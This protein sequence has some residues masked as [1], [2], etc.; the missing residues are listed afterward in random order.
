M[1][2]ICEKRQSMTR[3]GRTIHSCSLKELFSSVKTFFN[4]GKCLYIVSEIFLLASY[5][6][7]I[8]NNNQKVFISTYT[9]Y[10]VQ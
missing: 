10:V 3:M 2:V 5:S 1:S 4:L 9:A 7:R 8:S 6:L